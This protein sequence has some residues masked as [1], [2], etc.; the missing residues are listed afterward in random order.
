MKKVFSL[1][2]LIVALTI[3][4]TVNAQNAGSCCVEHYWPGCDNSVCEA[5]VCAMDSYCCTY[6]WDWICVS[7]AK[8]Q[9]ANS[10]NCGEPTTTTTISETTTTTI[11]GAAEFSSLGIALA[12]L[13]TTP[14]FAYLII[15]RRA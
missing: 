8:N 3:T 11:P 10:C 13:L 4:G 15:R 7:E 2:M 12:V 1:F 9:C 6:Y 14:A 5:C